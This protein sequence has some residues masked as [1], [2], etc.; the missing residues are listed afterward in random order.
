MTYAKNQLETESERYGTG[1]RI[2]LFSSD[3]GKLVSINAGVWGKDHS[4]ASSLGVISI[5]TAQDLLDDL[6]RL[7][8]EGVL[9]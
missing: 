1:G 3:K 4:R 2:R 8:E 5:R 7:R 6:L 9:V